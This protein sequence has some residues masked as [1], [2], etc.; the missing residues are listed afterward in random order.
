MAAGQN[1]DEDTTNAKNAVR[2][3][4]RIIKYEFWTRRMVNYKCYYK[5][6]FWESYPI[7]YGIDERLSNQ[8]CK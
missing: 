4:G 7:Y 8:N 5:I 1:Y 3:S 6:L 2:G